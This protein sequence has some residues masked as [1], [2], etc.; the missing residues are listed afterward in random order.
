MGN[1]KVEVVRMKD[2]NE[3]MGG[4]RVNNI[5]MDMHN[6]TMNNTMD[7]TMKEPE[8]MLKCIVKFM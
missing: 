4:E 8:F 7:N 3:H 5:T 1:P 6:M 2:D